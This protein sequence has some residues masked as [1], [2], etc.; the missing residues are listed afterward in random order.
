MHDALADVAAR[1]LVS[2]TLP[3]AGGSPATVLL[4]MTL[5]QL[6]TRTGL[7]TTAHGGA[8]SVADALRIADEAQVVPVVIDNDGVLAFG[9]G[10]RVASVGQ[11]LALT[12]RDGGCCFPGCDAPP[13]WTQ[14]H[15]VR[16]WV[17]G[18]TTDLDNLCLLC[19][20]HHREFEKRGWTVAMKDGLPWWTPPPRIDPDQTPVPN[21]M[22]DRMPAP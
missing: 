17:D 21:A 18:G 15:H 1:L 8:T 11:R 5:D 14:A 2:G 19:G 20:Y 10:R 9:Q 6:E 22:H 4:T 7:V 13:G 12:A 16:G 3:A